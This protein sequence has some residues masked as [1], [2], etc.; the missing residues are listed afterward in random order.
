[1]LKGIYGSRGIS[2]LRAC[3]PIRKLESMRMWP[4]FLCSILPSV[5]LPMKVSDE[6]YL[7]QLSNFQMRDQAPVKLCRKDFEA[8]PRNV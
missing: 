5:P 1:M 3:L 6:K 4:I 8:L 2:R 7:V